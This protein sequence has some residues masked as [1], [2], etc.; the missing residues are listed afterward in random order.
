[1]PRFAVAANA[2]WLAHRSNKVQQIKATEPRVEVGTDESLATTGT[3]A[4]TT[5]T[6]EF[7]T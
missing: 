1:M 7:E 2:R 4:T 5:M 3:T 6:A